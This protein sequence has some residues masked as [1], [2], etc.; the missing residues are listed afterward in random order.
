MATSKLNSAAVVSNALG[1]AANATGTLNVYT[2]PTSVF[3]IS[4]GTTTDKKRAKVILEPAIKNEK[5][6][7][8]QIF[9]PF[10]KDEE[11]L[12][13]FAAGSVIDGNKAQDLGYYFKHSNGSN[14]QW[15][16]ENTA[17]KLMEST[18]LNSSVMSFPEANQKLTREQVQTVKNINTGNVG[19]VAVS[20]TGG[21]MEW[22]KNQMS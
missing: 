17:L 16:S 15:I 10:G 3:T 2:F 20:N 8:I 4:H 9:A 7:T 18:G 14:Y 12:E 22:L 1:N 19:K 11:L 13:E 6:G 21:V 5:V